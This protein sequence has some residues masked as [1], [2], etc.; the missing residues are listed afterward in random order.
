MDWHRAGRA[1]VAGVRSWWWSKEESGGISEVRTARSEISNK[2][3]SKEGNGGIITS[4]TTQDVICYACT[5]F[6]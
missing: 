3:S 5:F 2:L 1:T 4:Y 6:L